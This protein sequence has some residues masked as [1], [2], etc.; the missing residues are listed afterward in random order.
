V[1]VFESLPG[2]QDTQGSTS[3]RGMWY[4]MTLQMMSW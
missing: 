2:L 3:P 1:C 4:P